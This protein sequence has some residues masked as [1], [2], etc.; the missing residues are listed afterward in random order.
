MGGGDCGALKETGGEEGSEWLAASDVLRTSS[1][2][3]GSSP[4]TNILR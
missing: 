3:T 4:E 2:Y 1:T